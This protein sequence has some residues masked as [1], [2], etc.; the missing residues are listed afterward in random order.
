MG[1]D[2]ELKSVFEP[3]LTAFEASERGKA[4]VETSDNSIRAMEQI[5]EAYRSSGGYF[6]NGYNAG[7]VMW[8]MGLSW[9][10]TVG[11]MLDADKWLP[12]ARARELVAL[13]EARPLTCE[14]VARHVFEHMTDGVEPHPVTGP[15]VEMIEATTDE[16]PQAKAPPDLDHLLAFL[17]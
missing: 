11:P 16:P 15:L 8:A 1:V 13:I 9:D 5:Y 10:G 2:I 12:V 7:D 14:R 3:W 4:I 6:R 17:T